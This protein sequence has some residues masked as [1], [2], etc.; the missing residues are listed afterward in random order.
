VTAAVASTRPAPS[1]GGATALPAAGAAHAA[2]TATKQ[3]DT[4]AA[5]P[6]D[7][8]NAATPVAGN[9]PGAQADVDADQDDQDL[10]TA[11]PSAAVGAQPKPST[12][13]ADPAS[14]FSAALAQASAQAT[15]GAHSSSAPAAA[16]P[17]TNQQAPLPAE[18]VFMADNHGKIVDTIGGQLVPGGGTM[19]LTLD[20]PQLGAL[21][22]TV[23][24][25]EGVMNA[26]FETSNDQATRMLGHSLTDLKAALETQGISVGKLEV[27]QSST[28]SGSRQS[29]SKQS[30]T[31]EAAL[32]QEEQARQERQRKEM[33]QRMWERVSIGSDDLDMV[34]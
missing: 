13:V 6:A 2:D 10:G 1:L 16:T 28:D 27:R 3:Q 7:S 17:S 23:Q 31:G 24:M 14:G 21:R 19:R 30:P 25:H 9:K 18:Q 15:G 22:I 8:T 26:S 29:D 12:G 20:P 5:A 4:S 32:Q 34:A 11:T 33:L